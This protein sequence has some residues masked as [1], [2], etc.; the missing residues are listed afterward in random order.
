MVNGEF[1]F[2]GERSILYYGLMLEKVNDTK[3]FGMFAVV[4]RKDFIR[5]KIVDC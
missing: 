2:A 4:R 3:G 1:C 5:D